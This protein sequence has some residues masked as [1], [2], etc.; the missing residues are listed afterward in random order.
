MEPVHPNE[1]NAF[2]A[3][4]IATLERLDIPYMVVGGFAAILYGEPR[5]TLDVD[6]VVDM[7]EPHV[8]AFVRAFPIPAYYAS[9]EA[10]RNSLARR[11]PFNVIQSTTG[12]KIDLVPLPH[13]PFTRAAFA[14]R[15]RRAYDQTG[16]EA[17][18]ITAEDIVV[19]KCL[20]FRETGSDRHMRDA[21]GVLIIQWEHID[22]TAV[23]RAAAAA[24]VSEAFERVRAAAR[25]EIDART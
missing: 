18:F 3:H 10:I 2:L 11:Y 12:A 22:L 5:L 7:R 24:G 23:Q 8:R 20:A 17:F 21:R 19:A 6:I 4:A 9:E 25:A 13:D 1:L 16:C 15:Q 14:R